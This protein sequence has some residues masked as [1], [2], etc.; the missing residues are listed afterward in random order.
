MLTKAIDKYPDLVLNDPKSWWLMDGKEHGSFSTAKCI[1]VLTVSTR[2][3]NSNEFKK[4]AKS[5][6]MPEVDQDDQDKK[7]QD[8]QFLEMRALREHVYSYVSEEDMLK[9]IFYWGP[10][11]CRVFQ[12]IDRL[13]T[14][15]STRYN[16]KKLD[17]DIRNSKIDAVL[18]SIE[19][20]TWSTAACQSVLSYYVDIPAFDD[21]SRVNYA[22]RY[23]ANKFDEIILKCNYQKRLEFMN[24]IE[25]RPKLVVC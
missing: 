1:I 13:M 20:R 17:S 6:F 11:P 22:S 2:D 12:D 18:N 24:M 25:T 8:K 4:Q 15:D 7:D 9:A 14:D 23:V 10:V 19:S 21:L 16:V 5:I 3:A